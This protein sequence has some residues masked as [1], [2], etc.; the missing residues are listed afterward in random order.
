MKTLMM[1]VLAVCFAG[2]AT[3]SATESPA[4]DQLQSPAMGDWHQITQ[5]IATSD[6][7]ASD[8]SDVASDAAPI[9]ES[10]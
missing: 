6:P 3:E 5:P 10:A 4:T 7:K 9:E 8:A 1:T 2:C